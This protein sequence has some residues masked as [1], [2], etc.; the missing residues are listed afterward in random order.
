MKQITLNIEDSKFKAFIDFI[1]TLDYVS[2]SREETLPEW[3]QEE[4]TRRLE[5][6]KKGNLET[7]NWDDVKKDT[8]RK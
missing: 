5:E 7:K 3:Q 4:V 1:K 2:V 8:F 6:H